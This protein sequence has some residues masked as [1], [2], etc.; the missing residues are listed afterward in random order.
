MDSFSTVSLEGG[1]QREDALT[2]SRE[3]LS[4]DEP[5]KPNLRESHFSNPKVYSFVKNFL[6][7]NYIKIDIRLKK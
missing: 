1:R 5:R 2:M 6:L 3:K 7:K 4:K